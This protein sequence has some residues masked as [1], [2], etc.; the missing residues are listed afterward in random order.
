MT[1]DKPSVTASCSECTN[2]TPEGQSLCARRRAF[3]FPPLY[4]Y[5]CVV[6]ILNR[7][8][9]VHGLCFHRYRRFVVSSDVLEELFCFAVLVKTRKNKGE[10]MR[11][12]REEK[13]GDRRTRTF[14]RKSQGFR[15]G[16]FARRWPRRR[17]W[18]RGIEVIF[19]NPLS[20]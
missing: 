2:K 4:R 3:I 18:Q 9:R 12:E 7:E 11:G 1:D 15:N 8:E 13:A 19:I 5:K 6:I 10:K 17:W 16:K 14:Q 20:C